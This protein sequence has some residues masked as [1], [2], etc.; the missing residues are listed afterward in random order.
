MV[1]DEAGVQ[2]RLGTS[3]IAPFLFTKLLTPILVETAKTAPKG[4][5]R[6]VWVSSSAAEMI[7]PVGG[8]GVNN[9]DYKDLSG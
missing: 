2:L 5:A 9:L 8:V 3:D 7:A 4:S 1:E 6:V